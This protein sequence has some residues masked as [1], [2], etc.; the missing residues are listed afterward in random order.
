MN[1]VRR[2]PWMLSPP[3]LI[4]LSFLGAILVGAFMLWLPISL[5]PGKGLRPLDALFTATSAICVTGLNVIDPG[6][7][8]SRF[9]EVVLLILMQLGG[10]GIITASAFTVLLVGGK[11][12]VI[13]RLRVAEVFGTP[14]GSGSSLL[15]VVVGYTLAVELLGFVLLWLHWGGRE[16]GDTWFFALFHA[17]S[18]FNNAGFSLYPDSMV[19]FVGDPLTSLVI[20]GLI[21]AG[22]FGYV[23]VFNLLQHRTRP[24]LVP[25]A[26]NTRIVMVA[27]LGLIVVAAVVYGLLEWNNPKTLGALEPWQRFHAS[28]F[29]SITPRT[30]GFNSVD[31]THLTPASVL[32]TLILMF[33][34]ASPA[35]TGGGIK[36]VTFFVLA[37]TTV[38]FVRHGG[39]PRVL[40]RRIGIPVILKALAITFL[41]VQ[42]VG[43]TF[44]LLAITEPGKD[45]VRLV[46]EA[47]SAFATVGLS[48]NLTPELS[49]AGRV[50]IIVL[51][52]FGRVGLL[53]FALALAGRQEKSKIRYPEEDVAIG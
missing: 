47:V 38:S 3:V 9:G 23:V 22:G 19:R 41:G 21:V 30:A 28:V 50:A 6:T 16:G 29:L 52:Y 32:V 26:L 12:G 43:L 45:P 18:A 15:R 17:V 25:L 27:T 49:D 44:T 36:T 7:T 1:S 37:A 51:M 20:C 42:L 24:N 5:E 40:N 31:Y 53:T 46:F 34:G 48:M 10:L 14:I 11:L 39:E 13:D 35:S 2:N 8:F 4:L 33:I